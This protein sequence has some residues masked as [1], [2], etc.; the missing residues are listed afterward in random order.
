[1]QLRGGLPLA[2]LYAEYLGG[3]L[4]LVSMP[5]VG[6]PSVA[7]L[8][9]GTLPLSLVLDRV[10]HTSRGHEEWRIEVN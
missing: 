3:S 4:T 10:S 5:G 7:A 6:R 2:R 1:M 9:R 8:K